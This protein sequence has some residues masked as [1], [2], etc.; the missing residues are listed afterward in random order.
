MRKTPYIAASL[1]LAAS[2]AGCGKA[3]DKAIPANK[4]EAAPIAGMAAA[5]V[6]HGKGTG[7]VTAIDVSKGEVTLD[8]GKIAELQW[9]PMEMG[10]AA[11]P[12]LLAGIK[13]GDRVAFE[14]DWNGRTGTI[15]K[16]ARTP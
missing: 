7:T 11:D 15:T 6:K 1:A 12:A 4:A 5:E 8:H 10:F 2:V 9:P 16:I 14:I 3:E 13:A